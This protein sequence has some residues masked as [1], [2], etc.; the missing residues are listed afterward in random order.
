MSRP[1]YA[2]S[3]VQSELA[4]LPAVRSKLDAAGMRLEF[5][6]PRTIVNIDMREYLTLSLALKFYEDMLRQE[7]AKYT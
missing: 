5:Y 3:W 2:Q 4:A 7:E 1:P 6:G